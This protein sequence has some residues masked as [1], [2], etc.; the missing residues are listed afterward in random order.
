[1]GA[2]LAGAEVAVI[3]ELDKVHPVTG[4]MVPEQPADYLAANHLWSA[5]AKEVELYAARHEFVAFQVLVRGTVDGLRP[6]LTFAGPAQDVQAA[7]GRYVHVSV[8][9]GP[10]PDP[11]MPLDGGFTVPDPAQRI[12]GQTSGSLHA[13]LYVPHDT[14]AG[15]LRAGEALERLWLM[16]TRAGYAASLLTQ[17][18]EVAPARS[19][20]AHELRL[21]WAPVV[22]LRIGRA[23]VSPTSTPR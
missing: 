19:T 13:E 11:I 21:D 5:A 8:E 17:I 9:G 7:F 10:L 20:L 15:W 6:E 14:P 22:L 3:D 1:M 18:V 4:A 2:E 23:P 16:V 12:A